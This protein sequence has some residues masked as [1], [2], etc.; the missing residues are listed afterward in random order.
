MA[1]IERTDHPVMS[2]YVPPADPSP[3]TLGA[4]LDAYYEACKKMWDDAEPSAVRHQPSITLP[5]GLW[6]DLAR[7]VNPIT[8]ELTPVQRVPMFGCPAEPVTSAPAGT[9][10]AAEYWPTVDFIAKGHLGTPCPKPREGGL[11]GCDEDDPDAPRDC[12]QGRCSC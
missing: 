8:R 12:Y 7:V 1:H 3:Y 2:A 9:I 11:C 6:P 5:E 10:P 4:F